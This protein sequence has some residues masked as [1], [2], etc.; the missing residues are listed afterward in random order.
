MKQSDQARPRNVSL[1][2]TATG[3]KEGTR[4]R[5]IRDTVL[6]YLAVSVGSVIGGVLRALASMAALA[7]LGPWFPWGT[8]FVN[9]LG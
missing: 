3:Q 2:A 8:L 1:P 4:R 6:L 9:V 7:Y 5:A